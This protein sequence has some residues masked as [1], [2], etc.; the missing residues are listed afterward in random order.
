MKGKRV[1]FLSGVDEHSA[2]VEKAA[3]EAG[4]PPQEYCDK[5]AVIFKDLHEKVGSS[6]SD[7]IRTSE[8]RHH[9]TTRELLRRSYEKGDIYK[10]SYTGYYCYSCEAYYQE[11]DL[12]SW[13]CPVH[14]RP[15]DWIEE[16]N[17][18]FKLTS[19]TDRLKEYFQQNP[20]FVY[21]E[22]YKNEML[23]L[24]DRGLQDIS[25]SRSTTTWGVP[26]PW[27]EKH[28]AY[29]WYD[30]LSNYLTGVGFLKDDDL[31]NTF[32]PADAHV[33]GKGH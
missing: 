21:P 6:L 12:E 13:N 18:F 9:D 14:K 30:A 23:S 16:E 29:V 7:F 1:Y 25:I 2:Q 31:F 22:H 11:K 33:I 4:L 3:R 27:D 26:L 15:V 20:E 28:V 19:Y 32:W 24:I 10:G 17:Y 8:P 5:M